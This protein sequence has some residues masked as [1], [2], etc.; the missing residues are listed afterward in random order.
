MTERLPRSRAEWVTFGVSVAIIS[1]LIAVLLIESQNNVA[2]SPRVSLEKISSG[3][4]GSVNVEVT[5]RNYGDRAATNVEIVVVATTKSGD[6]QG[7]Q[8][9]PFLAGHEAKDIQFIFLTD[10]EDPELDR[11]DISLRVSSYLRS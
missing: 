5:A 11:S 9:I 2:A 1:A 6:Q 10:S 7:T 3:E 8:T 4:G